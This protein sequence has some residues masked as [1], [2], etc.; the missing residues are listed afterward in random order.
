MA[1][2]VSTRFD[3]DND[4]VGLVT[5]SYFDNVTDTIPSFEYAARADTKILSEFREVMRTA[6]RKR[7][8]MLT[9]IAAQNALITTAEAFIN[10]FEAGLV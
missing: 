6:V 5:C 8:R 1:W 9:R 7:R 10:E 2:K 3:D 4:G